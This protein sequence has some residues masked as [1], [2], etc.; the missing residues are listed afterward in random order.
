M[1]ARTAASAAGIAS[2][3]SN[4]ALKYSMVPPTSSG[5]APRARISSISRAASA[6][7]AAA[8]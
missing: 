6:T 3:P 1:R 5:I 2:M 7:K 8:L 4:S